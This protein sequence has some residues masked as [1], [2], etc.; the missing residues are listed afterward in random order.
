[1][2]FK[3]DSKFS[4]VDLSRLQARIIPALVSAV[5]EASLAVVEEAKVLCP[6]D[7]GALQ[8]SIR[9]TAI[10]VVGQSVT[11]YVAATE[12]YASFVEYGT[13]LV[14]QANPHGPLPVAGVPYTGSWVYDFRR[15]NWIG[16]KARPFMRPGLDAARSRI[17]SAFADRGFKV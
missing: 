17:V 2:N 14:G 11:G 16:E 9:T 12:R 5:T 13:G 15:Q 7:T 6:V 1:M 8:A 10:E 3:A 4:P